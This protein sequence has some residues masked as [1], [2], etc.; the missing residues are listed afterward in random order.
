[1]RLDFITGSN[2]RGKFV[3]LSRT[4]FEAM[5]GPFKLDRGKRG[6]LNPAAASAAYLNPAATSAAYLNP[7]AGN[8]AIEIMRIKRG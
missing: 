3:L 8:A 2:P 6:L 1:M 4:T 5:R 7:A